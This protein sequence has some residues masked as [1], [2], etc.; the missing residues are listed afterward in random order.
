[1]QQDMHYNGVYV[2]ARAAGLNKDA[3]HI[4]ANA[5]QFVDDSF[6]MDFVDF[7]D[8][9]QIQPVVT[10][11]AVLDLV[12]NDKRSDQRRVWLPFHFLPACTGTDF[13][14]KI[15]CGKNS[16]V[17]KTM[18]AEV[19]RLVTGGFP[20]EVVG[21]AAH[22]YADT[23]SHY[24]FS[25]Y[26]SDLNSVDQD[27]IDL[28]VD[29]QKIH[30]YI[31]DKA[32]TYWDK[33]RQNVTGNVAELGSMSLGHSGVD[34]YPDRPYLRWSFQYDDGR[35][36]GPRDNRETFLEACEALHG[37]FS[38]IVAARPEYADPAGQIP[39]RDIAERVKAVLAK[40]AD[41]EGRCA[42]WNDAAHT[43]ALFAAKVGEPV[44]DYD[45]EDWKSL[46]EDASALNDMSLNDVP[47][48]RFFQGAEV[49][50]SFI[51]RVLLPRHGVFAI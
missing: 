23:F 26:S 7:D 10:A 35:F 43:G 49:L 25:G 31:E 20:L 21:I 18:I 13:Q 41:M 38:Q 40:E 16:D 9:R 8:S 45:G 37:F 47:A 48:Y 44:P 5:S 11:H 50:R 42:A 51:L 24:G 6:G 15:V 30:D 17:A 12:E 39:F 33:I 1:M 46:M 29:D 28:K 4:V 32:E 19:V 14:N 22:V 3:A 2:L 36:S 34:T 27:S